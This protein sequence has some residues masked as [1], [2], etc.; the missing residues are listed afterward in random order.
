MS[1]RF[2]EATS[3]YWNTECINPSLIS[4]REAQCCSVDSPGNGI[5]IFLFKNRK[6]H[7]LKYLNV[8]AREISSLVHEACFFLFNSSSIC[9]FVNKVDRTLFNL[10][11]FAVNILALFFS[12]KF[13]FFNFFI[14]QLSERILFSRHS[15]FFLSFLFSSL[16]ELATPLILSNRHTYFI[17][18]PICGQIFSI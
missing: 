14:S 1:C 2:E 12:M 18:H 5:F 8:N 11:L 7:L 4:N 9:F 16:I 3:R 17:L 10:F 13:C 6:Q 15:I